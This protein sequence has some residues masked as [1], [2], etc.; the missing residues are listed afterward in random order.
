[1]RFKGFFLGV[2]T[3]FVLSAT[4]NYYFKASDTNGGSV[5]DDAKPTGIAAMSPAVRDSLFLNA[6][7]LEGDRSLAS[8]PQILPIPRH[9]SFAGEPVPLDE[10]DIRERF[11]KELYITAHRYYQV[12]FYLKRAPRLLPD[13]AAELT[14]GG[15]PEDFKYMAVIESDLLPTIESPKGAKGI[16]QFMRGTARHYGLEVNRSIDE[17]MNVKKATRAAIEYLKK[18]YGKTG[19]WTL[20]AA[21]YNMG[22]QGILRNMH[23]QRQKNY[24]KLYLNDETS[25]YVFRILAVKAILEHPER[26][27]YSLP[28]GEAYAAE[29]CD[30]ITVKK[31]IKDVAAWANERGTT[32]YD[33]KRFNPWILGNHLP[34]GNYRLKI[35]RSVTSKP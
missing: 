10:P 25:R 35:P 20:A 19:S 27:G 29:H 6:P 11:E 28:T 23:R 5:N 14:E 3:V 30:T 31:G 18:A 24:Y 21:S 7:S 34:R 15:L 16:W 12:I 33:V 22:L 8:V 17:R 2:A 13:L 9:L 26:Y 1:M 32:Y 4:S